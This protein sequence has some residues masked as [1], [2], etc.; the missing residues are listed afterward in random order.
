[1]R[2]LTIAAASLA[3]LMSTTA[4]AGELRSIGE[5]MD[6]VQQGRVAPSYIPQRCAAVIHAVDSWAGKEYLGEERW[7]FGLD[8]IRN[9]TINAVIIMYNR[10]GGEAKELM[11]TVS[12]AVQV[13]A[14]IYRARMDNNYATGGQGWG[15]D[16]LIND[17]FLLCITYA[18]QKIE[19]GKWE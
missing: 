12:S 14:D 4:S 7:Q 15:D 17:D 5:S 9:F 2:K 19:S 8:S 1:M 6:L 18:K 3:V 11:A 16:K 13:M 10:Q